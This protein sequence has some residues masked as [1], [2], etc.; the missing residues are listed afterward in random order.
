M[1]KQFGWF[2]S[3]YLVQSVHAHFNFLLLTDL[4]LCAGITIGQISLPA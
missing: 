2:I 1:I 3:I 4:D